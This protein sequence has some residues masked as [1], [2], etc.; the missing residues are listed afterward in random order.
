MGIHIGNDNKI[1]NSNIAEN[2][3]ISDSKHKKSFYNKHPWVCGII[4]SV[5]AGLIVMFEFWKNIIK[6]I[7]GCFNG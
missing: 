1:T 7:E 3:K 5:I 4:V 6:F 2:M